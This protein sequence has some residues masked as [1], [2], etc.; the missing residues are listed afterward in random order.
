MIRSLQLTDIPA[1][2]LFLSKAPRNEARTRDRLSSKGIEPLAAVSILQ[3]C[4]ISV[5]KQH[6]F[7]CVRGGFI[8]GLLCL[9]RGQG[10]SAWFI[11]RLMLEPE[12]N[13][14][15][16]D[17]LERV[18]YAGD[19]IKA[20]RVFLRLD[21]SSPTVDVARQA[22]FNHYLTEHLY[23]L[24]EINKPAPPEPLPV[25]RSKLS[26][27]EHALFRLY[28][29][30]APLQ[31]RS[32]EGM[33]LQEWSDSRDKEAHRE[34]VQENAGEISAWLRIRYSGA[35]GRFEIFATPTSD[36]L[37]SLVDYALTVL[38]TRRPVYC[39]VPEYQQ[40]LKRILEERGFYQAGAYACLSKQLAVRVHEPRL[41]PL[42]A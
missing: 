38:K 28:S 39:L 32:A 33:T 8:Q 42:R 31:V 1:L 6:S 16:I 4:L 23:R 37:P 41:V 35:S 19:I 24:D 13:K 18:G 29:A 14:S 5:D 22:G 3:G 25:L 34:L 20:E 7:V 36:D 26:A 12:Q 10:T 27:D 30:S 9:R 2:L 40:Q 21:S 11:E 15:C 17:L